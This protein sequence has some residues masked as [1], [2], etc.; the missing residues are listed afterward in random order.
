MQLVRTIK[1]QITSIIHDQGRVFIPLGK[2]DG[3]SASAEQISFGATPVVALGIRS[4]TFSKETPKDGI[5]RARLVS[6]R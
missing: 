1:R 3:G 4:S 2:F 6:V 5:N